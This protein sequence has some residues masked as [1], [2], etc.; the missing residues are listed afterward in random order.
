FSDYCAPARSSVIAREPNQC[1]TE[2]DLM[3]TRPRPVWRRRPRSRAARIAVPLAIPMALGL[4]LGA[5]L[6]FTGGPSSTTIQQSAADAG[7]T[8]SPSAMVSGAA[9]ASAS[10]SASAV[11]SAGAAHVSCDIVVPA[12]P[13]SATGLSTPYQLTGT[14]GMTPA[15][16]GCTTANFA[17]LGAF[18][19]AT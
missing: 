19:Q 8:A 3:P 7:A 18:V 6:A 17:A 12:S 1:I 10:A 5:V 13:L 16:S 2:V 11:P 4:T 9:S 15:Q 14:G